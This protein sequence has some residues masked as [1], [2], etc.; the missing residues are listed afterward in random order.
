MSWI[1]TVGFGALGVLVVGWLLVSFSEPGPRRARLEWLSA[2]ALFL[3]L[4]SLF[5]N[6]VAGAESRLG[7]VGFSFLLALFCSG[8]VVSAVQ[9]VLSLRGERKAE[10][11]ATH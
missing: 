11:S 9:T 7:A 1:A 4:V 3:A 5:A 8:L 6:L 10:S 2:T